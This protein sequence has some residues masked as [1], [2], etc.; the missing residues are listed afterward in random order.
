MVDAGGTLAMGAT[1]GR[2]A[3]GEALVAAIV[4]AKDTATGTQLFWRSV[5][6]NLRGSASWADLWR[7]LA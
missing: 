1:D 4:K 7:N 3:P 5:L 6:C 2:P